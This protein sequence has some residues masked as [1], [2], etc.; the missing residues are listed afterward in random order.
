MRDAWAHTVAVLVTLTVATEVVPPWNTTNAYSSSFNPGASLTIPCFSSFLPYSQ[1]TQRQ[2]G[3]TKHARPGVHL[4][5]FFTDS[6]SKLHFFIMPS[7]HTDT[8]THVRMHAMTRGN[9]YVSK[10]ATRET[11]M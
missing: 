1:C 7:E 10:E 11:V 6:I 9:A 3:V 8:S 4:A 5:L 2:Q